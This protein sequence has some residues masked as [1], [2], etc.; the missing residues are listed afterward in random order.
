M[1]QN[2]LVGIAPLNQIFNQNTKRFLPGMWELFLRSNTIQ[3]NEAQTLNSQAFCDEWRDS[4][5][6]W[7]ILDIRLICWVISD[8]RDK[9]PPI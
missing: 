5:H 3:H 2:K 1:S 4:G 7:F 8:I 6:H 9:T